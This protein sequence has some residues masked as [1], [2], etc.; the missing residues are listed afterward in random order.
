MASENAIIERAEM[1][2]RKLSCGINIS[3]NHQNSVFVAFLCYSSSVIVFI[4]Y[5]V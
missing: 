3:L 5:L 4:T 1:Y 2:L